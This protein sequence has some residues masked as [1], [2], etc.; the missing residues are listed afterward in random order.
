[1]FNRVKRY[2]LVIELFVIIAG[3]FGMHCAKNKIHR[4][5]MIAKKKS[6]LE[7]VQRSLLFSKVP[8]PFKTCVLHPP[9]CNSKQ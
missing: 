5:D 1:M 4:N 2:L 8:T 3:I 6:A 9:K 7:R